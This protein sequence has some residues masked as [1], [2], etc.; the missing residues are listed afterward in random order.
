[1]QTQSL[2]IVGIIFLSLYWRVTDPRGGLIKSIKSDLLIFGLA[3]FFTGIWFAIW[4]KATMGKNWNAP[5]NHDVSR[6]KFVIFNPPPTT[7]D[8]IFC[9]RLLTVYL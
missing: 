2:L 7:S 1:M 4:A 8:E 6:Q 9:A 3:L 5:V